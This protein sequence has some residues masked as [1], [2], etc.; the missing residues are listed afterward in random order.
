MQCERTKGESLHDILV[1]NLDKFRMTE[2]IFAC[3]KDGGSNLRQC[4]NIIRSS[5]SCWSAEIGSCF[6]GVFSPIISGASNSALSSVFAERLPII[7]IVK[8]RKTLQK[9]LTWTNKSAKRR[10]K[11]LGVCKYINVNPKHISTPVQTRFVSVCSCN[12][13]NGA[14]VQR[15]FSG[16]VW[17]PTWPQSSKPRSE[18]RETV[19]CTIYRLYPSGAFFLLS[20]KLKETLDCKWGCFPYWRCLSDV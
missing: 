2:K 6:S 3:V 20:E 11:W 15:I 1:E 7:D 17:Y 5:T 13:L 9:W 10:K 8:L 18:F 12:F 4:S 14:L 19:N 16:M